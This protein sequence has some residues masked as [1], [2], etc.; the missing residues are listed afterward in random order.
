[1]ISAD[2]DSIGA[3]LRRISAGKDALAYARQG[4]VCELRVGDRAEAG[5]G[6]AF[7]SDGRG[8]ILEEEEI[9]AADLNAG[10]CGEVDCVLIGRAFEG[11]DDLRLI[12]R[13]V[14]GC[15]VASDDFDEDYLAGAIEEVREAVRR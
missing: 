8:C 10:E 4:V 7:G 11:L 5:G 3:V 9:V 6:F 12:E 1:M 14:V 15:A 2:L 13:D